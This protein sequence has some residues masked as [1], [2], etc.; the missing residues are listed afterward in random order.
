[1]PT[2]LFP[3]PSSCVFTIYVATIPPLNSMV[4]EHQECKQS[5]VCIVAAAE[6]ICEACADRQTEY[7]SDYSYK[8][9][10]SVRTDKLVSQ[11]KEELICRETPLGREKAVPVFK[12]A[13]LTAER[14]DHYEQKAE[15][16]R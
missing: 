13:L 2:T 5:V 1:M 8:N 9:C 4:K 11:F 12:D 15:A 10:D 7:C 16:H 3:R 6:Y 14:Y